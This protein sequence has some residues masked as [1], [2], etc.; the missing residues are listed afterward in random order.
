MGFGFATYM[1]GYLSG[2]LS[3]LSPCVLP[4]LP[5]VLGSAV[6][7]GRFGALALT[8]GTALSFSAMGLLLATVGATLG[9]NED[10]FRYVAAILLVVV[11]F[12]LVSSDPPL[13]L[14]GLFVLYGL[15]GY[16]FW[17]YMAVRGRENPARSIPHAH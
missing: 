7:S 12:V 8:G 3:T 14:F 16:A 2:V 10:A 5:I 4:L 11:A 15:S 6:A 1:L 17:G 13:M 9:L